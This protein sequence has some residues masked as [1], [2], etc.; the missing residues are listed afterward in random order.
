MTRG[1]R[2]IVAV[3]AGLLAACVINTFPEWW[4][5]GLL[6][7]AFAVFIWFAT[8]PRKPRDAGS[9]GDPAVWRPWD[10]KRN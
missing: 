6:G 7:I 10:R 1:V 4:V 8:A 9:G 3:L 2:A 5:A